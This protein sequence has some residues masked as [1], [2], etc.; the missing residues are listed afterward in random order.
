MALPGSTL[1]IKEG[2]NLGKR[3]GKGKITLGIELC[4]GGVG[5]E[6]CNKMTGGLIAAERKSGGQGEGDSGYDSYPD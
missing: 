4:W 3:G 5:R 2:Q 6:R 1:H